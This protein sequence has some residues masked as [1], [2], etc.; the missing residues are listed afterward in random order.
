MTFPH[1]P[2]YSKSE[3]NRAGEVLTRARPGSG[4]YE[5]A[6]HI[7]NEWRT[8]HA[9]PLNTFKSTL[10]LKVLKYDNPIVAQRLKRLPT[11][12]NKLGRYPDMQ[13]SRMQD[14]GGV[15][16]VIN[17]IKE[18]RDLQSQYQD[19]KRFTHEL[20]RESDYISNPKADGYRGVHLVYKYNNTLARNGLAAQYKG[21][22]VELQIRTK[23]QHTWATAVETMG[24]FRNESFKTDQG[25]KEWLD[26]F[27]LV[28]SAF[29]HVE[30]T[31]PVPGYE[32]LSALETYKAVSKAESR[33]NILR[34]IRGLSVAANAIHTQGVG[35][36]YN[37]II[38]DRREKT[39]QIRSFS[40]KQ[41]KLAT[42]EYAKFE[43]R[44]DENIDQVLVSAGHLKSLKLAYPNYFLDVRDFIEKVEVIIDEI[45]K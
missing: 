3:I 43:A 22:A 37:L 23:L 36:Y 7:V 15:R 31:T 16:A 41:L 11:I 28:S 25:S 8:C 33:L 21:L 39:V 10:R 29:A 44:G 45:G 27:A 19:T 17:S 20:A 1:V 18:V 4:E 42:T 2:S 24:T 6:L 12:V 32:T 26:F 14:I 40:R 30:G 38:L 34:Q 35:D 5:H 13:L 9:Y